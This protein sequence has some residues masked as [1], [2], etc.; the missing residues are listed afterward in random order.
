MPPSTWPG[1][2]R[3]TVAASTIDGPVRGDLVRRLDRV[4]AALE[5][6]VSQRLGVAVAVAPLSQPVRPGDRSP[7][8]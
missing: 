4:V 7:A 6:V 5:A 2:L 8:R 1:T 3:E